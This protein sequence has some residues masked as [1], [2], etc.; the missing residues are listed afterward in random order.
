MR[1]ELTQTRLFIDGEW[2]EADGGA[3]TTS[4]NPATGE[5]I[6]EVARARPPTPGGPWPPPARP[7]TTA[8]GPV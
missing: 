8:R 5:T 6:A 7:S 1:T 3:T 2:V 4:H